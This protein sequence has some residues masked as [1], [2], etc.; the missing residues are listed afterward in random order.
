MKIGA[1]LLITLLL[2]GI[3]PLTAAG[4]FAYVQTK[5]ELLKESAAT[6]EALRDSRKEQVENYF[7]E[8]SKNLESLASS[9]SIIQ[10][11]LAFEQ[12]WKQGR[13]SSAYQ[14]TELAQGKEMKMF[15]ARYGFSNFYLVDEYGNLIFEAKAQADFGT[16]LLSGSYKDTPLGQVVSR[17]QR[18]QSSEMTDVTRYEPSGNRP[19]IFMSTPIF[20]NSRMIGQL[21]AEVPLDYV[22]RLL[23]RHDGLGQTGKI[24]LIGADKTFRSE[25]ETEATELLTQ[26]VETPAAIAALDPNQPPGTTQSVDYLGKPVLVSYHHVKVGKLNWGILAEIDLPEIMA[27]PDKIRNAILLFNGGV[28]LVVALVATYT[29]RSFR[30]PMARMAQVT[31]RIGAGDFTV[32]LDASD[33]KRPDEIGDMARSLNQMRGQLMEIVSQVKEASAALFRSTEEIREN[34]GGVFASTE[35]IASVTENVVEMADLQADKMEQTLRLAEALCGDVKQVSAN[36]GEVALSAAEMRKHAQAGRAAIQA[37]I[38][39]MREINAVVEQSAGVIRELERR[40]SDISNFTQIITQIAQ[41]TNMLALNA[42]IEAARAGEHGKG[43]AVVADEVRKLSEGTNE[44]AQSIVGMIQEIQHDTRAAAERMEQGC[45][46]V[47]E[48][49]QTARE[50]GDL[51]ASIERSI[52]HVTDEISGVSEAVG[53]MNP[54]AMEVVSYAQ[55]VSAAS[56]EASSGMQSISAAIEEQSAAMNVIVHSTAELAKLAEALRE[57]LRQFRIEEEAIGRPAASGEEEANPGIAAGETAS[58]ASA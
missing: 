42:A 44:A 13:D 55:E 52:G 57:S 45:A 29:A 23:A 41:Q 47:T 22:S 35:Q 54:S 8:R 46:K 25:L 27:G 32:A 31:E 36:T 2:V 58:V 6:L 10:S 39:Q 4:V 12:V 11:V 37:V 18:G 7:S 33:L 21:V 3:V 5:Q 48:G 43:F 40:S 53:R 26:K 15:Q 19:A 16:N 1:R 34:A 9:G 49:L 14:E 24:Y 56:E 51:F 20:D 28:L 38:D 17:V 30:R 50:S